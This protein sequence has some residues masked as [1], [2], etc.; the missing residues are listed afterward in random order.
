MH[1]VI[2]ANLGHVHKAVSVA[3]VV[4]LSV[5]KVE[6]QTGRQLVVEMNVSIGVGL[7]F[8]LRIKIHVPV[9]LVVRLWFFKF[10]VNLPC[11]TLIA[12]FYA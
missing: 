10:H 6:Q 2:L 5:F 1:Q 11:N 8:G 7:K 9:H 12:V 4:A 3:I